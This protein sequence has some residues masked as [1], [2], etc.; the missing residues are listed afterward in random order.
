LIVR[1]GL[2][3][4]GAIALD[5]PLN[6]LTKTALNV[7]GG[8]PRYTWSIS[9]SSLPTGLAISSS[10][11][12]GTP[13]SAGTY[14]ANL[15]VHDSDQPQQTGSLSVLIRVTTGLSITTTFL[16]TGYPQL[17][18]HAFLTATGGDA[19]YR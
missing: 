12:S 3:T 5:E 13:T 19:P 14:T 4:D 2:A 15:A 8:V 6:T 10:N 11:I 7:A 17:L 9:T 18:Y 1:Q 16:P